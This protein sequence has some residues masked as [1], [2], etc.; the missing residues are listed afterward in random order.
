MQKSREHLTI[1]FVLVQLGVVHVLLPKP[2]PPPCPGGTYS[3]MIALMG[4]PHH[5]APVWGILTPVALHAESAED[6]VMCEL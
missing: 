2:H 1:W 4:C 5:G 3:F 6:A